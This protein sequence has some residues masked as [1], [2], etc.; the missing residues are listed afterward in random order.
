[1]RLGILEIVIII[2]V[3]IAAAFITRIIR[4]SR[5]AD[6]QKEESPTDVLVKQVNT[7]TNK[8]SSFLHRSGIALIL[9][10]AI[11]LF[12][13]IG[14]FRWAFQSYYWSFIIVVIGIVLVILFR[15]K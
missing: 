7:S 13:G 15:K 6:R 11:I 8:T 14:M 10:G 3:I 9:T 4:T 5:N 2:A 12:A 1:M